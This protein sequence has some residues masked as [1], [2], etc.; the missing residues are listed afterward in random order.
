MHPKS[1]ILVPS[2]C[3]FLKYCDSNISLFIFA[4]C[5]VITLNPLCILFCISSY[6]ILQQVH[7]KIYRLLI[8]EKSCIPAPVSH[9]IFFFRLWLPLRIPLKR[10]GSRLLGAV[11]R[12]FYRVQLW[13]PLNVFNG[14]D[15]YSSSL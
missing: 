10:L 9:F 15:S 5:K 3:A 6:L 12:G 14:H 8:L 13:L 11:F 1:K 7:L 2:K 4:P